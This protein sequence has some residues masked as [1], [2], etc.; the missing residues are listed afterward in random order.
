MVFIDC[1]ATLSGSSF[2]IKCKTMMNRTRI[3]PILLILFHIF[4]GAIFCQQPFKVGV[5]LSGGGAKGYAHVGALKIIEEAGIR[6]DYIAG[7]SMGAIIG[8]LYASGW[9]ASELDS[10]LRTMDMSAL[11]QDPIPRD[12]VPFFNKIYGEKYALS[13]SV[14]DSKINLPVALSDGQ[15]AFNLLSQLTARVAYERDFSKLPIPFFCTGTDV[16]SG[17]GVILEH[18]S[19]PL[20]I[21]ASGSFPGLLAPVEINN[22]L[23]ADGGIINNF[24]AKELKNKGVDLVI[25]VNVESDLFEKQELNSVEKIIM[26][27]S[28]FQ[29]TQKSAEQYLYCDLLI[30]PNIYGYGIT[31]FEAV[32][33]LINRGSHAAMTIWDQLQEV[34]E[35]QRQAA[36]VQHPSP[37]NFKENWTIDTVVIAPNPVYTQANI[38]RNFPAKIPGEITSNEFFRGIVN[39]YGTG[40]FRF[41]DYHFEKNDDDDQQMLFIKPRLKPGYDRTFKVGLH[42]DDEYRSGLLLNATLLNLGFKNSITS[43]DLILGDQFRYE[44]H[45]YIDRGTKPGFGINSRLHLN[46]VNFGLQK[47]I[48]L[49]DSS[50]LGSLVFDLFD[51]SNEIYT[52]LVTS[53]DYAIGV[54]AELK[55]YKF[56]TD[57][58]SGGLE[59]LGLFN[60]RGMYLTGSLFY[61]HDDRDRRYF[62]TNGMQVNLQARMIYEFPFWSNQETS[63]KMGYNIDLFFQNLIPITERLT[64]GFRANAG[65]NFNRQMAPYRYFL[66]GNNLNVINNFKQFHGLR[67]AEK[68]GSDL[69]SASIFGQYRILK[70]HYVTLSANAA[71]LKR[72]SDGEPESFYSGSIGYGLDTPLGPIEVTYARFNGG[73]SFYFNLGYWF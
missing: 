27:I 23:I 39:L 21:R 4:P 11:L 72:S 36:P 17:E 7:A 34:A 71:Y 66:G 28:S 58:V 53:N 14:Q 44:F 42:Y 12:I 67:F 6:I 65:L 18:G 69:A 48:V 40:N 37:A 57:Q 35:K 45:Y 1:L 49:P 60:D 64:G 61:K 56:T 25:G 32:D 43:I 8:G 9:T 15:M 50:K 47:D 2:L 68:T 16:A 30:C 10:I 24:P 26:Q 33:T 3:L 70:S 29:M 62:A 59:E 54:G 73:D 13:L 22:R 55:Y 31:N 20:A 52:H 5:V 41:V 38:L 63:G 19:L 46:D 51:F